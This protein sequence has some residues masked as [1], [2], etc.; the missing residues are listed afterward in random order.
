MICS[1]SAARAFK[2]GSRVQGEGELMIEYTR[3]L[4]SDAADQ[5]EGNGGEG[6]VDDDG[7]ASQG[8]DGH[9][10]KLRH[11]P[12]AA[13]EACIV[14]G[15]SEARRPDIVGSGGGAIGAS[16]GRRGLD[17]ADRCAALRPVSARA[18]RRAFTCAAAPFAPDAAP[19]RQSPSHTHNTPS[20]NTTTPT[21]NNANNTIK[22]Q[23][24]TPAAPAVRPQRLRAVAAR[25]GADNGN[26]AFAEGARVRVTAPVK[27][28]HV[29]K[30]PEVQL[31]GMEGTVKKIAALHKGALLSA[32]LQYRVQFEAP[33]GEEGKA[34]KFFAHL[35]EEEIAAA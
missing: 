33:V 32:N 13:N 30:V 22:T 25:A 7:V 18:I 23:T 27:V 16:E 10:R 9:S 5:Q 26:F 19:M 21:T 11:A 6:Q 4:T 2:A 1:G 31:E 34:V 20:P 12:G 17:G 24:A 14:A 29:P 3:Y 35:A 8:P 28:Y 15:I